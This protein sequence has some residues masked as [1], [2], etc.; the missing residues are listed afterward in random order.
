MKG[1]NNLK[2]TNHIFCIGIGGIGLSAIAR[3]LLLEGKKVSGSD[4]EESIVTE[5]LKKDGAN[6]FIGH[7]EDNIS[8]DVDMVLYTIAISPDNPELVEAKKRGLPILTYPEALGTISCDKKTIAIAGTHGKTTTTAMTAKIAQAGNL[9]PTVIVGSLLNNTDGNFIA[10]SGD[11]LIVE[12]C[13]YRRSFLHLNP[14]VLVIT[15]IEEDHLDYYKDLEDIQSAFRELAQKVP[16]D[17][18]VICN[19]TH[20]TVLPI[21]K[22]LSCKVIDYTTYDLD[23]IDLKVLGSFNI[24]NAKAAATVGYFLQVDKDDIFG[25]LESFNGTWRRQEYKGKTKKGALIYDDYAHHPTEVA[26]T[27]RAFKKEYPKKVIIAVF[28]PHLY[29][30]TKQFLSDFVTALSIADRILLLPIY[31]AREKDNNDINSKMLET[32]IAKVNEKVE[33][34][35]SLDCIKEHLEEYANENDI[36]LLM[37]AGDIYKVG[38]LLV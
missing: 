22:D 32:A 1:V 27:I 20:P 29:S 14:T 11:N 4:T 36:I 17:G 16:S 18:A 34:F 2:N 9:D 30:R 26:A 37:G 13:E 5:K 3:M 31:A 12:A 25:G 23:G 33:S 8:D 6:I 35:S 15:N 38:E 21:V 10:G 24:Q 7:T 19:A 28:Q